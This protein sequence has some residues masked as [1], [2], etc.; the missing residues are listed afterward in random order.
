MFLLL[1]TLGRSI[2]R[3]SCC[4]A[5]FQCRKRCFRF[6]KSVFFLPLVFSVLSLLTACGGG[7]ENSS[8]VNPSAVSFDVPVIYIE[9]HIMAL[10]NEGN[11]TGA[12]ALHSVGN[13][14]SVSYG[15]K[16]LI[17]QRADA[18]APARDLTS[19][20]WAEV[21]D[22]RYDVKDVSVSDDGKKVLFAMVAPDPN[23]NNDDDNPFWNIWEYDV[24]ANSLR[25]IMVQDDIANQGH[26]TGPAYLPDGR[27]IFTSTRQHDAKGILLDEGKPQYAAMASREVPASVIH[28]MNADGTNIKQLSFV[29]Q[30]EFDPTV[31]SNGRILF[32]R[33]DTSGAAR[34]INWYTMNADGTQVQLQYGAHSHNTG[35]GNTELILTRPIELQSGQVATLARAMVTDRWGGDV[36]T[37]N[38]DDFI[39]NNQPTSAN[40]GSTDSAQKSLAFKT[41]NT[42]DAVSQGGYIAAF[43]PMWDNSGRMIISWTPCRIKDGNKIRPCTQE[44]ITADAQEADPFYG[45]WVYDPKQSTLLPIIY[46]KTKYAITDIQLLQS[47]NT[48]F[49]A[50]L[51]A[52]AIDENLKTAGLGMLHIRSIYDMDGTDITSQVT[53]LSSISEAADPTQSTRIQRRAQFLRIIKPMPIPDASVVNNVRVN[54]YDGI[55]GVPM[56]E[57]I[58]YVPIEPDGSA[59]FVV[60]ASVPFSFEIVDAKGQRLNSP[61]SFAVRHSNWLQV[62]PGEVK[63]CRGCHA[64]N[65]DESRLPHGR[66]DAEPDSIHLGLTANGEYP[67]TNVLLFGDLGQ[68]MAEVF[69][70]T[71]QRDVKFERHT[72]DLNINYQ[73]YW[74]QDPA[75]AE[76]KESRR[77]RWFEVQ[78]EKPTGTTALLTLTAEQVPNPQGTELESEKTLPIS[79]GCEAKWQ[80][81]CRAVINYP[82][83]IQPLWDKARLPL[84]SGAQTDSDGMI[85]CVQCH[86][87]VEGVEQ[88]APQGQLDLTSGVQIFSNV[89]SSFSLISAALNELRQTTVTNENGE[90]EVKAGLNPV[91]IALIAQ[92][93]GV[94]SNTGVANCSNTLPAKSISYCNLLTTNL[95]VQ[96]D[97]NS[98]VVPLLEIAS[99][100]NITTP[101]QLSEYIKNR[102]INSETGEIDVQG[103]LELA[104]ILADIIELTTPSMSGNGSSASNRFFSRFENPAIQGSVNHVGLLT[105]GELRLLTEWLDLGAQYYNNAFDIPGAQ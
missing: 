34:G 87:S 47:K 71:S 74:A 67:N 43:S 104:T 41:I 51:P 5:N 19:A 24:D 10:D 98:E 35:V 94:I 16:L 69:D 6:I 30:H 36:Q 56:T 66:P 48:A 63:E 82:T 25:R 42:S 99:L 81:N 103:A 50:E 72:P 52:G 88:V 49:P 89:A 90:P 57:I 12:L 33:Q 54:D 26:D 101:E 100:P 70:S 97:E 105:D 20:L 18:S 92:A 76:S 79:R 86:K 7:S 13:P 96:L 60:P 14:T 37:V 95:K 73:D 46:G 4:F 64:R 17:R 39:D 21:D 84:N 59:K 77:Y 29:H 91:Q 93:I 3:H 27:I 85:T 68:S 28:I 8:G 78:G 83:H 2:F 44:Q 80:K 45:M 55:N 65:G 11:E 40:Q 62:M 15:A 31:L 32:A 9:R 1:K 53:P 23:P 61:A 75:A 58:G 38:I 22:G 102:Y